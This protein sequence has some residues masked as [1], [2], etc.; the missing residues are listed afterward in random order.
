MLTLVQIKRT[1]KLVTKQSVLY[2]D[3]TLITSIS[4]H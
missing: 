4:P 3:H 2:V 1:V